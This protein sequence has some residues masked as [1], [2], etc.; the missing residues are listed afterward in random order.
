M[1]RFVLRSQRSIEKLEVLFTGEER[2]LIRHPKTGNNV[3]LDETTERLSR[4]RDEV[5]VVRVGNEHSLCSCD[6]VL[7]EMDVHL[8]SDMSECG[9]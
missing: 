7:R 1:E 4:S 9:I 8:C 3:I 2:F 5:L 6:F